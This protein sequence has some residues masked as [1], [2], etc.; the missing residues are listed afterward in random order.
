MI[1][2]QQC[3]P[4]VKTCHAAKFPEASTLISNIAY[5]LE[6]LPRDPLKLFSYFDVVIV[7]TSNEEPP[8]ILH[9]LVK[10]ESF[11]Q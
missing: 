2:K 10:P 3:Y 11:W 1:L 5:V 7:A 4:I 9:C 8:V 6:M